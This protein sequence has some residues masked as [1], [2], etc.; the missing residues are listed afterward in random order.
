MLLE[1][2]RLRLVYDSGRWRADVAETHPLLVVGQHGQGRTAAIATDV[3]PHWVG[4]LVD[5]GNDR[6]TG[7]AD[8]ADEIEVGNLYA[9][10]WKQLLSYVAATAQRP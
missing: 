8:G 1:A 5:W 10:F 9:Q 3:A 6:V 4:G 2:D 7:R